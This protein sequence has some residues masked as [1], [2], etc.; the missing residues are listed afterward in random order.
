M[1]N[2]THISLHIAK[3]KK[4]KLHAE[5]TAY[6]SNLSFLMSHKQDFLKIGA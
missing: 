6:P 3:I 2:T 5:L 1:S 4:H